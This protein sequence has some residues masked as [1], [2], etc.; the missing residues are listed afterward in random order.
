MRR[1]AAA[2][3]TFR[4]IVDAGALCVCGAALFAAF[5]FFCVFCFEDMVIDVKKSSL[6]RARSQGEKGDEL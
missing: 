6:R 5:G 2:R 4:R 3:P 1:S